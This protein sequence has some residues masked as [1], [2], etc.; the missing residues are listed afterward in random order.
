MGFTQQG[1]LIRPLPLQQS[2]IPVLLRS[3]RL[4]QANLP[5]RVV[6]RGIERLNFLAVQLLLCGDPLALQADQASDLFDP[7]LVHIAVAGALP[8]RRNQHPRHHLGLRVAPPAQKGQQAK[9]KKDNKE[10]KIP[11]RQ[12]TH[13]QYCAITGAQKMIDSLLPE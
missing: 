3:L 9:Q 13:L 8:A 1:L 11:V 7:P 2:D 6:N 12:A 5:L 10:A 4:R